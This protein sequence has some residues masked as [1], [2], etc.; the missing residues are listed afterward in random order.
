MKKCSAFTIKLRALRE[1]TTS[2]IIG[3]VEV[4]R[5]HANAQAVVEEVSSCILVVP[6]LTDKEQ[7]YPDYE[8]LP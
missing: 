1:T 7:V 5:T 8:L 3:N 6:Q 4:A 2:K